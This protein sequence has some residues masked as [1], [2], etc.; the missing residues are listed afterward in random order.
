MV[1]AAS[2]V[3]FFD[4]SA[5]FSVVVFAAESVVSLFALLS[6]ESVASAV[7]SVVESVFI[8]DDEFAASDV[9]PDEEPA[10]SDEE[11]TSSD[12]LFVVP[13]DG[14]ADTLDTEFVVP[15]GFEVES[16]FA[17]TGTLLVTLDVLPVELVFVLAAV[18]VVAFGFV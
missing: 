7:V 4:V 15:D 17:L 1:F 14:L 13:D 6:V 3:V 2:V 12:E 10:S 9:A 5:L 16:V 18:L 8:P 11:P